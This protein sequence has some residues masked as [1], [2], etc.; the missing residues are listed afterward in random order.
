MHLAERMQLPEP[1]VAR[2]YRGPDD[3]PAMT[4]VLAAYRDHIGDP[5]MPTV[6]QMD[7]SYALL[8]GCDPANDIAVIEATDGTVISYARAARSD[9]TMGAR[10]CIVFNPIHPEHLAAPLYRSIVE[11]HERHMHPWAE[12]VAEARF[13]AYA[14]HPGPD[15]QPTEEAAWLESMGYLA[16]EWGA[17]LVRPDLDDI[18]VRQLPDGVELRPVE[19]DQVRPIWEEHWEAFRDDWDFQEAT[20]ADIDRQLTQPYLDPS[21]W[22]V[23]WVGD[24][25]VGQVKSYINPEEN[26]ARGYLR[27]YTEN[28]ATHKDWR[29][30]G[31]AGTLLAMSLQELRDRGMTEAALGVDTNNPGGAFQLYTSFGFKPEHYEAVYLKPN[32]GVDDR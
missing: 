9:L 6:G 14:V 17:L 13:R 3:H 29:N 4:T 2:P 11:A 15:L 21:L 28:I 12:G 30:R 24:Q 31:I 7:A 27:G 18:P 25:V 23:A 8:T 32:R 1:Y 20:A 22:K 16:G 10:D 5:E 26:A 19:P